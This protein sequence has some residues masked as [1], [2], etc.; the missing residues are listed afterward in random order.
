MCSLSYES[1][2]Q[3]FYQFKTGFLLEI[4]THDIFIMSQFTDEI[5]LIMWYNIDKF[6]VSFPEWFYDC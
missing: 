1:I 5:M 2:I 4:I 3:V 6:T